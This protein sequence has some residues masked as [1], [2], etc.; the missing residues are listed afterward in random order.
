MIDRFLRRLT[1]RSRIVGGFAVLL[2][3]MA[4]FAPLLVT[5]QS[6][7]VGRLRQITE[8]EARADRSLLLAAARIE[9]SRVNTMRYIQDYAPSTY[10]A[11]DDVDQAS[12]L[13]TEARGLITAPEQQVAVDTVLAGLDDYRALVQ[14]VEAARSEGEGE[15]VSRLLFQAYRLGNDIGQRIEQMVRD[16][17]ERSVAGNEA[18]LAQIQNRLILVGSGYAIAV[19]LSLVL[20]SVIQRSITRPVAELRQ[21]ADAFRQ[22][23]MDIT[24]LLYTSPSPRD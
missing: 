23:E 3:L 18:I 7:I 8:V 10:E 2:V 22:G 11:L 16:S 17:E 21:G 20:S 4:L 15:D 6:F 1:V 19:I 12:E 24:C 13:L 5:S 14:Q 9:S